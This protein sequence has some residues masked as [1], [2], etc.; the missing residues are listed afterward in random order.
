[1][2]NI[3]SIQY[4][5]LLCPFFLAHNGQ[6]QIIHIKNSNGYESKTIQN[7]YSITKSVGNI[8]DP[9]GIVMK[10]LICSLASIEMILH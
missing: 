1:M 4:Q 6:N 9:F 5:F 3:N 8:N 7:I 10:I 2:I